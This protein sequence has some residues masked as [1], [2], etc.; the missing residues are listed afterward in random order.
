V[1]CPSDLESKRRVFREF[2]TGKGRWAGRSPELAGIVARLLRTNP[3]GRWPSMTDVRHFLRDVNIAESEEDRNRS[4]AKAIYLRLQTG[5]GDG[6]FFARFYRNLFETCPDV[7]AHFTATD[8]PRQHL[9]LNRAIQLLLDFNPAR[10][11][12]Q[13]RDLGASHGAFGLTGS[14]YELFLDVLVRTLEQSGI[15]DSDQLDAWRDTL[16]RGVE[17]M[18]ICQG[19]SAVKNS[20]SAGV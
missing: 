8:M 18:R 7:Q 10:G 2:E 20:R 14:H 12:E 3:D 6:E 13:L 1:N 16:A 4:T 9:M 17:F 19:E 15:T 5:D 11:S